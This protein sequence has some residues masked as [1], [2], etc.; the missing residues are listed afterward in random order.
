MHSTS[1]FTLSCN[2]H[3]LTLPKHRTFFPSYDYFRE[4]TQDLT[5]FYRQQKNRGKQTNPI[6]TS[7]QLGIVL[8]Y[9]QQA[10]P[11][12]QSSVLLRG[13]SFLEMPGYP[14]PT[15]LPFQKPTFHGPS[16]LKNGSLSTSLIAN[17]LHLTTSTAT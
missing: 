9:L 2:C 3:F 1:P 6:K 15:L 4:I 16:C 11:I 14:P 7:L 8:L 5:T 13:V 17:P 12:P 10:Y